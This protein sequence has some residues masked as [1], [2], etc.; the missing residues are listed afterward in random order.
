MP[1]DENAT[2]QVPTFRRPEALPVKDVTVIIGYVDK[3]GHRTEV[4][5]DIG[6]GI[7]ITGVMH[8]V[9]EK[10][11]KTKD[12]DGSFLGFEPTGEYELQLKVKYNKP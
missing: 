4:V 12:D 1:V 2:A 5:H 11:Q 8:S 6:P 9:V 3:D 10:Q 7:H